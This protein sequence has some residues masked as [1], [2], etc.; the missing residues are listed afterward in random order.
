LYLEAGKLSVIALEKKKD[1]IE[2]TEK[3]WGKRKNNKKN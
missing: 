3:F 2:H 1:F